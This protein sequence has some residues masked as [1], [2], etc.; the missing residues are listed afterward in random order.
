MGE[1]AGEQLLAR[2]PCGD[3]EGAHYWVAAVPF[4]RSPYPA[5]HCSGW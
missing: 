2:Y 5:A 4:C 3:V 1:A